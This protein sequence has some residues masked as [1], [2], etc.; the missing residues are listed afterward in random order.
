[1]KRVHV[2]EFEDA[3]WFPPY[4]RRAVTDLIVVTNRKFGVTAAIEGLVQRVH[5]AHPIRRIVDMGSGTGGAMPE[6]VE[7]LRT[8]HGMEVAL[9]L[10]DL[11]PNAES[12][13]RFSEGRTP[14]V[15]YHPVPMDATTCGTL[16]ADLYTMVNGFHHMRP[17]QARDI[18]RAAAA[19][20][21]PL[22][23]V[24]VADNRLPFA[25]W[26]T[27]LPLGLWVNALMALVFTLGLRP[28]SWSRIALTYLVPVIP[29]CFAWDGQASYPRIY[30]LKDLDLLL[31]DVASDDYTW[32]KGYAKTPSG[33]GMAIYLY[34]HPQSV[35]D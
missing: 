14:G 21:T 4:L 29:F 22:L 33:K 1:M 19:S 32:E 25:V 3:S 30:G 11:Y 34:G 13:E 9:V 18:L 16:P 24:E 28:L 6:V 35:Q 26:L 27:F 5:G 12:V 17:D 8:R 10:T 20:R 15:T 31:S 7:A 23:I 2:F